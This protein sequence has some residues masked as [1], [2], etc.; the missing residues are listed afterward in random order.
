MILK[1]ILKLAEID[2]Q[3]RLK[4]VLLEYASLSPEDR[5]ILDYLLDHREETE[6]VIRQRVKHGVW[7][8]VQLSRLYD[9]IANALE[10]MDESSPVFSEDAAQLEVELACALRE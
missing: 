5:S 6:T 10:T 7:H 8:K 4:R 3:V 9:F 1:D 2:F